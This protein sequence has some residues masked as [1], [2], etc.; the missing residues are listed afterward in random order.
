MLSCYLW[1]RGRH[2][3]IWPPTWKRN[4][5]D[6]HI[7]FATV[8]RFSKRSYTSYVAGLSCR[9]CSL[10]RIWRHKSHTC[11]RL[12]Y[13]LL[14][15]RSHELTACT[16]SLPATRARRCW[17]T[18]APVQKAINPLTPTAAI[19]IDTAI[20]HPVPDRAKPS[21]VIFD[22]R[23]LWRSGLSVRVPGCQKLKM[24]A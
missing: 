3:R 14:G 2:G 24:T 19:I 15:Q 10:R 4:P 8:P 22:I 7:F 13:S 23:A 17:L 11:S 6:T 16:Q 9:T 5:R 12:N 1:S 18:I 21:F 20:K